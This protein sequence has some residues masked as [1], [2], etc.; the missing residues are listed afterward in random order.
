V[1]GTVAV[2]IALIVLTAVALVTIIVTLVSR[3]RRLHRVRRRERLAAG[4]R[5][6]L[7]A[8]LVG[9]D[10]TA[11]DQLGALSRAQWQALE[12]T[13]VA[14]LEKVSGEA[15]DSL[16]ELFER[17]G[18]VDHALS[19]V[20]Q[21]RFYRC[22]NAVE[23]LGALHCRQAL[24]DLDSLLNA[25][26]QEMRTVVFRALGR[27]GDPASAA[28][29]LASLARNPATPASLV[30]YTLHQLGERSSPALLRG[31]DHHSPEVRLASTQA[32]QLLGA[33]SAPGVCTRVAW[34]LG[35]DE[36]TAVRE[37]AAEALARLG[38]RT[39]LTALLAATSAT[40]TPAVRTAAVCALGTLGA[41]GALGPLC[42]LLGDGEY[43]VAH[44]AA[45]SLLRL[46][47]EGHSALRVRSTGEGPAAAH[48][49]EA[50]AIT[51]LGDRL[52]D[53]A[54]TTPAAGST[55]LLPGTA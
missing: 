22:A 12:P 3:G 10:D 6:Q 41:R 36:S 4:P 17:H 7:V 48:A 34:A 44:A 49:A 33:P 45:R 54:I 42:A 2:I 14:M 13:A 53:D 8:L 11:L 16:E 5:R 27:I 46:G 39:A 55:P 24:A 52:D 32:V 37:H 47:P 21:A 26:S 25:P 15:R 40:Q 29:M 30:A 51:T 19:D 28:T 18:V 9:G 1:D 31:M 43:G 50:F 35:T 38:T 20:R 23:T